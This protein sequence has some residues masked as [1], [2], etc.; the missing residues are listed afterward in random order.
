MI[1][2]ERALWGV[3]RNVVEVDAEPVALRV[4]VGEQPPLKHFVR[5]K[6]DARHEV[7]RRERGLLHF[8][9]KVVGVAVE[10]HHADLNQ[11]ILRFR[12][13]L[14]HVERIVPVGFRLSLGHHLDGER[15]A[16]EVAGLDR[17]EQVPAVAFA[18][19]GDKSR[20]L[21]VG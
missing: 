19:P 5:R 8:G 21:G 3:D 13:H 15:P 11:R 17:I 18:I 9:E 14:G 20:G 7:G 16:R 4:T 2:L 1:A 6:T 10:L 12:P